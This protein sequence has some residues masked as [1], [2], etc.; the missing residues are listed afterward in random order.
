MEPNSTR[1]EGMATAALV[2]GII[3]VLLICCGGSIVLGA[4]GIMFALLSRGAGTM[5]TKARVGMGL[6]IGSMIISIILIVVIVLFVVRSDEVYDFIVDEFYYNY[7]EYLDDSYEYYFDD[8]YENY[9]D[10]SEDGFYDM[11]YDE[12]E[13]GNTYDNNGDISL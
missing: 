2:L 13:D 10:D 8:S 3:S 6:S 4:L 1:S 5:N 11:P 9:F 7:D 12:F